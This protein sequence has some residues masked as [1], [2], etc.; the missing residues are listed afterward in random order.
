MYQKLGLHW[1]ASI[2]AFLA[3]IC[4]PM[5]FVFWKYGPA[6]RERCKYASEAQA[7]MKKMQAQVDE[8]GSEEE[9]DNV[10]EDIAD[11]DKERQEEREEEEQQVLDYSY[12]ADE[13]QPRLEPIKSTASKASRPGL[14]KRHTTYDMSPFDLDRSNTRESFRWEA[15]NRSKQGSK[16]SR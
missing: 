16:A 6:I 11:K 13:E 15:I 9:S 12:E 1:A 14:L 10:S 5:P 3:L 4:V 8:D 2:P 7:F